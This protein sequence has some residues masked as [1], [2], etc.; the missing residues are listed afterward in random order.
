MWDARARIEDFDGH[1]IAARIQIKVH[2]W[3]DFAGDE[4][5]LSSSC[6]ALNEDDHKS[7]GLRVICEFH[8]SLLS[9]VC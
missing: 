3:C 7:V 6:A 4:M 9:E 5:S 1:G 2:G 8:R